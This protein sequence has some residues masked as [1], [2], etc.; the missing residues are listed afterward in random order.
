MATPS[1]Q[2]YCSQEYP[3]EIEN[4][5]HV[6]WLSENNDVWDK[7][8]IQTADIDAT[9]T[10]SWNEGAGFS[11]IGNNSTGFTGSYNGNYKTISN[12]TINRPNAD[13][14]GLFGYTNG[15]TIEKLSLEDVD[16]KGY[17]F[18]GGVV[19]NSYGYNTISEIT[20]TG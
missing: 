10:A 16:I 1:T 12:L 2:G 9:E 20:V 5:A 8:F 6:R 17:I 19:G 13:N 15:A 4:L 11:P 7:H 18:V 14:I 3:Y